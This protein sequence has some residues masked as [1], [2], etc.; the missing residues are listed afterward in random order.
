MRKNI[1]VLFG[2]II[3]FLLVSC[4]QSG[5][6][7]YYT[8]VN[9]K[10][11]TD[12]DL[13]ND[14]NIDRLIATNTDYFIATG[15]VYTRSIATADDVSYQWIEVANNS[16]NDQTFRI[17]IGLETIGNQVYGLF[18]DDDMDDISYA[19]FHMN[20]SDADSHNWYWEEAVI[21]TT[22]TE[23]DE[24]SAVFEQNGYLFAM[25]KDDD[26]V[27][28]LWYTDDTVS[29]DLD[30]I[31]SGQDFNW[32]IF[33]SDFYGGT[34]Y[35]LSAVAVY[36]S[37]TPDGPYSN[38]SYDLGTTDNTDIL[39]FTGLGIGFG[40]E[41]MTAAKDED[42]LAMLLRYNGT[43]WDIMTK[44]DEDDDDEKMS[45]ILEITVEGTD[46]VVFGTSSGYFEIDSADTDADMITPGDDDS[47]TTVEGYAS[48]KLRT[49]NVSSFYFDNT[50]G[51]EKLYALTNSH[52][53][54]R[55]VLD[56][57]KTDNYKTW[58]IE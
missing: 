29:P 33:D 37:A 20:T 23:D 50:P 36:F 24:I 53:L 40:G 49:Y 34:Y 15:T 57:L 39:A 38:L 56:P 35:F 9:D 28:S 5:Y 11:L 25:I 1:S 32:P 47:I 10:P 45:D 16:P 6:G 22:L 55:L 27:Y 18:Q 2:L 3:L 54:W 52:G 14:I 4:N 51:R 7:V 21:G 42:L 31:D 41:I 8:V 13:P 12:G 46:V 19:L 44:M 58:T 48:L 26:M 43:D 17:C 30:F